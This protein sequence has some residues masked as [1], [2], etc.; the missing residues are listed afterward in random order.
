M[1]RKQHK[2][3]PNPVQ[4]CSLQGLYSHVD[5]F[6]YV[7]RLYFIKLLGCTLFNSLYFYETE[8]LKHIYVLI[9]TAKML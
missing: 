4:L 2:L 7:R 6:S 3:A 9:I 5:I 1:I 8:T